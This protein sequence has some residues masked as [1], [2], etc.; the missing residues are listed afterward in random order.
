MKRFLWRDVLWRDVLW[1]DVLWKDVLW[2]TFYGETSYGERFRDYIISIRYSCLFSV[3]HGKVE[4]KKGRMQKG[5]RRC[6]II[7]KSISAGWQRS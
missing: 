4:R 5:R 6:R 7:K 2:R 1:R 3:F